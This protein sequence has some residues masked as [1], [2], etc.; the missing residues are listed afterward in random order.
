MRTKFTMTLTLTAVA[1]LCV[2]GAH[3]QSTSEGQYDYSDYYADYYADEEAVEEDYADNGQ[4]G[5]CT[6]CDTCYDGCSDGCPNGCGDGG[7]FGGGPGLITVSGWVNGGAT[8][9]DHSVGNNPQN[10]INNG[11]N[12]SNFPVRFNDREQGQLNQ[13]YLIFGREVDTSS[14]GWDV[15]GP[16][17]AAA[18][19]TSDGVA[20]SSASRK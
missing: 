5:S 3:A 13:V 2:S 4:A 1:A 6:T 11:G 15:G 8:L 10:F 18:R 20:M 14:R 17:A 7:F 12:G 16:S 19:A 9:N